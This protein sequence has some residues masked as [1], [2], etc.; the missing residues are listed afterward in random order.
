MTRDQRI[1]L[2][3]TSEERAR[4]EAEAVADG[5]TLADYLRRVLLGPELQRDGR[6]KRVPE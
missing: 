6:R 1:V 5:R 4:L 2:R 3:V